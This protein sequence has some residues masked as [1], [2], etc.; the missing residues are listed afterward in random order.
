M[1]YFLD[2]SVIISSII[3]RND[4]VDELWHFPNNEYLVNE[5]VV[6]EVRRILKQKFHYSYFRIELALE[7]IGREVTILPTPPMNV[8]RKIRITD[9]SDRPIVYSA[10]QY[11]CVLVTEDPL[12]LKEGQKYVRT[13]LPKDVPPE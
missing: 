2:S 3:G 9:K 5:Y 11:N 13:M 7:R 10:V 4:A 1:G 8:Y 12:L 6:K